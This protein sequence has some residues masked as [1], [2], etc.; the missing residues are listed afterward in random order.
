MLIEK[1]L[2]RALMAKILT[3]QLNRRDFYLRNLH[4]PNQEILP[5]KANE[6]ISPIG[7]LQVANGVLTIKPALISIFKEYECW[8]DFNA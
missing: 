2:A 5:Q 7:Q 1:D 4:S 3:Y 6:E 8:N